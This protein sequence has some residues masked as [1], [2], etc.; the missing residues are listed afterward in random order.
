MNS[1]DKGCRGFEKLLL[2]LKRQCKDDNKNNQ[3]WVK[4]WSNVADY[5]YFKIKHP[6]KN[7]KY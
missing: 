3:Q 1:Y 6:S 4:L 5:R 2:T 7:D